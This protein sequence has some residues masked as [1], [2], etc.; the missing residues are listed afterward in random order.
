[1]FKQV[2]RPNKEKLVRRFFRQCPPIKTYLC[3]P[4]LNCRDVLIGMEEGKINSNTKIIAVE[5]D[6][7]IA[8]MI[9]LK[10][11]GRNLNF[12]I[13]NCELHRAY[14]DDVID[15]AYLDVCGQ[16]TPDIVCW[17]TFLKLSDNARIA[18]TFN[19]IPRS[20]ETFYQKIL[21]YRNVSPIKFFGGVQPTDKKILASSSVLNW[22]LPKLRWHQGTIYKDT[23]TPMM[24][25]AGYFGSLLKERGKIVMSKRINSSSEKICQR[26]EEL[27][28]IKP[29]PQQLGGFRMM[30]NRLTP[31]K[32]AAITRKYGD[33]VK[34]LL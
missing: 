26:I 2:D 28:K 22:A 30:W 25:L 24:F 14:F 12:T 3:L 8:K 11:K 10:L 6:C 16:I 4:S 1:M 7:V 13:Y 32:K 19:S 21:K 20:H 5:K 18:F 27:S 33:K 29:R 9:E 31:G 15:A 34:N 23:S 17:L